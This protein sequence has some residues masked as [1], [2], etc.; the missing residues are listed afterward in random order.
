MHFDDEGD[1]HYSLSVNDQSIHMYIPVKP[2][3]CSSNPY[4]HPGNAII[5]LNLFTKP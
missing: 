4:R 1:L 2:P 3:A 5:V